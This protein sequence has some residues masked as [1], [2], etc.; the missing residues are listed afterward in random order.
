MS[1]GWS[2]DPELRA[3]FARESADTLAALDAGMQQL[4]DASV[5]DD[6]IR[7]A[8]TLKGGAAVVGFTEVGDAAMLVEEVLIE[9]RD[10]RMAPTD[11]VR[12]GLI[13]DLVALRQARDAALDRA[14]E[15]PV[16][17]ERSGAG[18]RRVLV[19][20][21]DALVR[22]VQ[23]RILERAGHEVVT[24]EEGATAVD[25]VRRGSFDLVIADVE[26]PG[27]DGLALARSIGSDVPVLLCTGH[28]VT[29]DD[30]RRYAEA[31]AAA[32]TSKRSLHRDALLALVDGL[33]RS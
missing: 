12:A 26:M 2:D 21:D 25:L 20:D 13:Q 1:G 24:A 7:R 27:T 16:P 30:A 28:D 29:D 5:L 6:L 11:G 10:G 23:R 22:Q 9:L 15:A 18:G 14:T 8:H 3:L 31:G 19:V 17:T 4:D 33:L 32:W